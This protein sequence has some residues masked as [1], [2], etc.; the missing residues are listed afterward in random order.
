MTRP[1]FSRD[2]VSD[3][4]TFERHADLAIKH[5]KERFRAGYSVDFQVCLIF[6]TILRQRDR[7]SGFNQSFHP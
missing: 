6:T 2:R 4:Y 1:F 5:M 7:S 3:F